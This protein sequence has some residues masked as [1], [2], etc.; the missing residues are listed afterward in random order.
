[1]ERT[2]RRS[3]AIRATGVLAILMV[4]AGALSPTLSGAALSKSK[5][6]KVAKKQINKLVPR[7]AIEED[8]LVRWGPFDLAVGGTRAIG[9]FGPYSLQARC[10]EDPTGGDA[11]APHPNESR[12]AL[13]TTEAD[14]IVSSDADDEDDLDPGEEAFVAREE[15]NDPAGTTDV[16]SEEELGW[17]LSPSGARIFFQTA[18]VTDPGDAPGCRFAGWVLLA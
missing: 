8:E 12:V 10:V 1:M 6:K 4:A 15:G 7:I 18:L 11:T 5:V 2:S 17:V 16:G 14:T 13:T 3:V 9:T